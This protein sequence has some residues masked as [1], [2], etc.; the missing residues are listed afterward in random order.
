MSSSAHIDNKKKDILVLGQG[1]TQELEHT[2]TAEKIYLINFMVTKKNCLSLHCNGADS[3]LFV[4]GTEIVKFKAKDFVIVATP[5]CLANISKDWSVIIM[6]KTGMN[7]YFFKFCAD[8][9]VFN[10]PLNAARDIPF[11]YSY[12]MTKRKIKQNKMFQFIKKCFVIASAFLTSL[13]PLSCISMA[14]KECKVRPEIINLNSNEPVFYPF[15]VKTSKCSS[16]CNNFNDP[17]EEMCVL[18]TAKDLRVKVFNPMS[19]TNETR[20]IK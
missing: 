1:P 15:S 17:Y 11:L 5:L 18:D 14:N 16:S 3:Y 19:R 8:Y 6:K 12:F 20:H 9:E 10:P 7:G 2:L 13:N 4:N